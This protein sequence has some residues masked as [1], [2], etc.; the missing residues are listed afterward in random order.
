MEKPI[1]GKDGTQRKIELLMGRQKLKKTFQYE[2][3]WM[4]LMHKH[5]TWIPR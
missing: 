4:G 3:K 2:I 1:T 5:N